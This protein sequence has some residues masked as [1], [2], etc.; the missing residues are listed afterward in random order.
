MCVK[1]S[2]SPLTH[3]HTQTRQD[4]MAQL[5]IM[6]CKYNNN[7]ILISKAFV[8][9]SYSYDDLIIDFYNADRQVVEQNDDEEL[10]EE[11]I[12]L[13]VEHA[14]FMAVCVDTAKLVLVFNF[15][16]TFNKD[17]DD[18]GHKKIFK[19]INEVKQFMTER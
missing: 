8:K 1:N 15:L 14:S 16:L 12:D 7:F 13:Y 4:K 10:R 5:W 17:E 19:N 9:G 2:F 6:I 18:E 3:T 11:I